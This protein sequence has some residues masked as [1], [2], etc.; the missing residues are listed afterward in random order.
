[1]SNPLRVDDLVDELARHLA[2][3]LCTLAALFLA[4]K[5]ARLIS[6]PRLPEFPSAMWGWSLMT[7]EIHRLTSMGLADTGI[8][9]RQGTHTKPLPAL[10]VVAIAVAPIMMNMYAGTVIAYC[11]AALVSDCIQ[12]VQTTQFFRTNSLCQLL[13]AAGEE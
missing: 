9:F 5:T 13:L 6:A 11:L 3:A 1:M 8:E 10:V 2:P 7:T 4:K 12:E